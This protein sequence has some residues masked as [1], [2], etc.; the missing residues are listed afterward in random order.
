MED[1]RRISEAV[2]RP[3]EASATVTCGR[4]PYVYEMRKTRGKGKCIFLEGTDCGIYA[5]RPLV[6]RFY[7]FELT[8]LHNGKPNFS[9]TG[10]CPG[11]G[12]GKKLDREYFEKLFKQAYD[13]LRK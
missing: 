5:V 8:T 3:V 4:E 1:A 7:P 11:L 13:Q 6:C 12:K 9:C 2:S 10:E